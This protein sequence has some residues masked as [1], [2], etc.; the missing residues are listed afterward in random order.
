MHTHDLVSGPLTMFCAEPYK[1]AV[2]KGMVR[3]VWYIDKFGESPNIDKV[4][5]HVDVWEGGGHYVWSPDGVADIISISSSDVTDN[6]TILVTGL[7]VNGWQVEQEVTLSGQ[8]R[9]PLTTPLW[10]VFRVENVDNTDLVGIVSIYAGTEAAG[11][12]PSGASVLKA[13]ITNG[14]NQSLMAIYTVPRGFVGFLYRGEFG[15]ANADLTATARCSYYSRRFG[16][17]F[18]CKKRLNLNKSGTSIYQDLRT[19]P[20][21]IPAM[22]DIEM[23]VEEVSKDG[24]VIFGTFDIMLVR[25]VHLDRLFLHRIGQ[26]FL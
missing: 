25:Q 24:T 23:T 16:S 3:D 6:Q 9:V 13:M 17:V 21:V 19:F 8:T 20:D 7:D 4:E 2:G 12:I 18:K 14:N 1:D 11:G 26:P 5:T 22:T 10:R 15:M